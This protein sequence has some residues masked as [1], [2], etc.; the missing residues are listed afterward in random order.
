MLISTIEDYISETGKHE[1]VWFRGVSSKSY[2]PKPKVH[3][4]GI[5]RDLEDDLVYNFLKDHFKYHSPKNDNP[6]YL[7]SL[8]QHHGLPTRLLDWTKSPLVA[9]YF[10]LTQPEE[11][12]HNPRVWLLNPYRLN[13]T[14]LGY[15][16]VYCPS[17]SNLRYIKTKNYFCTKELELKP[18]KADVSI[19]L[20]FDSYLPA[21]LVSDEVH[22]RLDFPIAIDTIPLDARMSAQQSVFTIHGKDSFDLAK[23]SSDHLIDYIDIDYSAKE[24]IL[25]QLF[26]LGF[27][28]D[29][30]YCTLDSLA[31]R[32]CRER[33]SEL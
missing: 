14:V 19:K 9:L 2:S 23:H 12:K 6:W 18:Y 1:D 4:A 5:S 22:R 11:K 13:S 32:I 16:R 31:Q 25:Q 24:K 21:N 15:E 10:A 7:Y 30:I 3:W 20:L 29:S 33:L 17:Q 26:K 8:M 28:E 27:N